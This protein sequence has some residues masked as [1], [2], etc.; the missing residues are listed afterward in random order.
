MTKALEKIEPAPVSETTAIVS[1]IER[2]AQ[3]P[4]V[5]VDKLMKLLELKERV[6]AQQAKKAYA[7]ALAEMQ[8]NLP[9]IAE[10][11][12]IEIGKG[13]PQSF[14]QWEDVNDA[15]RPILA[16]YGFA[17]S[18]RIAHPEGK[19]AVTGVLSHKEGHSEE[20]TIV[21]PNDS[22]G[23]KNAVQA[24]GSSVSYGKRYSAFALLNIT[25]RGEDDDG[26]KAGAS[27]EITAE[28][29]EELQTLI[30]HVGADVPRFLK[31]FKIEKLD[32]LPASKF[33]DAIG[34]LK[35]KAPN[36]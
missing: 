11:G 25:S 34:L 10:K 16:Q 9:V 13:K 2:A 36:E 6:D 19:V 32:D 15:I 8:P 1:M 28:Q 29:V 17:L 21:L 12:K 33:A 3:N 26:R 4:A 7:A 30:V 14:A 23:S 18:F 27:A 35:R 22:S 20:T 5:D 24:V 31:F